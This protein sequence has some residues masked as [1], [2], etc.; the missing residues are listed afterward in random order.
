MLKKIISFDLLFGITFA[1]ISYCFF[2]KYTIPLILGI[3]VVMI[4][5]ILSTFSVNYSLNKKNYNLISSIS[6]IFRVFLVCTVAIVLAKINV[7]YIIP[8]LIG[9][10][11]N[12]LSIIIYGLTLKT[13]GM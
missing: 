10:S 3:V 6:F 11:C 9:Y 7:Y 8:Y 1:V 13:E 4:S 5:F 2:K 12:F